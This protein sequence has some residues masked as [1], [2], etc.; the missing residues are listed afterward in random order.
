MIIIVSFYTIIYIF[1]L[2]TFLHFQVTNEWVRV[3]TALNI[4]LSKTDHPM[5][6]RFLNKYVKNGGA[7]PGGYQLQNE[8]LQDVANIDIESLRDILKG[9]KICVIFDEMS[10][11]EGRYVLNILLAPIELDKNGRV[12]AY[13]GDCVFLPRTDHSTV[14]QAV[15][16][17]LTEFG[18]EFDNVAVF[19]TD[20]AAY[21]KKAFKTILQ[22]LCVNAIHITCLAH[23][24][25]L[26][27]QS[28]RKPFVEVN[29]F[30][31]YFS[32]IFFNAGARKS[33]FLQHL[34]EKDPPSGK[35]RVT[36]PP[37]PCATRW[38]S[39]YQ[40][41]LYHNDHFPLYEDFIIREKQLGGSASP[42]SVCN[43][44]KL[45][46]DEQSRLAIQCQLAF[47][48]EHSQPIMH[49]NDVFESRKP[50]TMHAFDKLEDLQIY[51]SAHQMF[52][53]EYIDT[54]HQDLSDNLNLQA[55]KEICNTF[56][57][58]FDNASEKLSKYLDID[59][60][61]QPAI[62]FLKAC[63]VFN[64]ARVALLVN[65]FSYYSECIPGFANVP[66]EEY[67]LYIE[68]LAGD[69]V[70]STGSVDIHIFWL[71]VQDRVPV[72]AALAL[73]WK[74]AVTNSA[75]AERS[76]SIYNLVLSNRRRSLSE[77]SLKCLVRLYYNQRVTCGVLDKEVLDLDSDSLTV[78]TNLVDTVKESDSA[79]AS[80]NLPPNA[81]TSHVDDSDE[82]DIELDE[83]ELAVLMGPDTYF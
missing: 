80:E 19:D 36:M 58:S 45:L 10:D 53:T 25:N 56:S 27:G 44:Y 71:S 74:D 42:M 73:I 3:C 29:D 5:M 16:K 8:H 52:S 82:V 20:N 64:P 33:R 79:S 24:I 26:I 69:A 49:L 40:A 22:G 6:R 12:I 35:K 4:P 14:S 62:K 38:N 21:M 17:C 60:D 34:K 46:S 18:I 1:T 48:A 66:I 76:N 51:F 59:G 28:F 9:K 63:R 55:K 13:L 43:L 2:F 65:D 41:V 67:A 57:E 11:D 39:W 47:L 83:S 32:Q 23:I 50:C 72:L 54:L 31:R 78:S 37:D 81:S 30:V 7:I 70:R 68:K 75:D 77:E 15:V 61:G